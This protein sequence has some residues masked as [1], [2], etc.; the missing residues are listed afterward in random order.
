MKKKHVIIS[1][2]AIFGVMFFMTSLPFKFIELW[3]RVNE[4]PASGFS[5]SLLNK[6]RIESL[7]INE[8]DQ[9]F[10]INNLAAEYKFFP[11][12][13]MQTLYIDKLILRRIRSDP[14]KLFPTLPELLESLK[15]PLVAKGVTFTIREV[16]IGEVS[17]HFLANTEPLYLKNIV[18]SDL[19]IKA[20]K[21]AVKSLVSEGMLAFQDFGEN[22]VMNSRLPKAFFS[23]FEGDLDLKITLTKKETLTVQQVVFAKAIVMNKGEPAIIAKSFKIRDVFKNI[24]EADRAGALFRGFVL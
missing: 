20:G 18:I 24:D 10:E 13:S 21:I 7:A 23:E 4:F 3:F 22:I 11:H 6:I 8:R 16:R 2:I 19:H 12:P 5:G 14:I 15:R 9:G 1:C 17:V